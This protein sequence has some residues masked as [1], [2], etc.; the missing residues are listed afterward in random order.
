M[1]LYFFV[2]HS[3]SQDSC[4]VPMKHTPYIFQRCI[5]QPTRVVRNT[6]HAVWP[7][8]P[9]IKKK[10]VTSSR[11]ILDIVFSSV[12]ICFLDFVL[13]WAHLPKRVAL[14]HAQN[15]PTIGNQACCNTLICCVRRARFPTSH[16]RPVKRSFHYVPLNL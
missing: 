12:E 3:R 11:T 1:I 5:F 15:L 9:K 14:E 10:G 2:R 13:V 7:D 4:S 8:F 6:L 16:N